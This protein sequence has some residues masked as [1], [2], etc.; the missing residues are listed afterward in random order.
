M[1]TKP[2]KFYANITYSTHCLI[3]FYH[4]FN[5]LSIVIAVKQKK[6]TI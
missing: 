1:Y 3:L 2:A 4:I 6:I 5:N